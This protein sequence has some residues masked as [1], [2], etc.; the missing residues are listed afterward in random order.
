MTR[1]V[2]CGRFCSWSS[3][4]ALWWCDSCERATRLPAAPQSV[5][6]PLRPIGASLVAVRRCPDGGACHH[7]CARTC[8]RVST[9]GP[10]SGVFPDDTWPPDVVAANPPDDV[11]RIEDVLVS[12]AIEGE[13]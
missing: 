2:E 5:A 9:C 7:A 4:R 11:F 3:Y 13:R 10:L 6:A 8:W 1:C 12:A